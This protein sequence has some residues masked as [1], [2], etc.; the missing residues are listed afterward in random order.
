MKPGPSCETTRRSPTQEFLNILWNS[1]VHSHV[2]KGLL[3][4]P[5]LSQMNP[6]HNIPLYFSQ[7]HFNIILLPTSRAF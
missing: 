1:K 2:H 3:L 6:D 4:V 7:I 5:N